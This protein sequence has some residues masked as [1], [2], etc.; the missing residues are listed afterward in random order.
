MDR[1]RVAKVEDVTLARRGEQVTGTLHL[2]PHH[3]IFSHTPHVSEEALASGTPIR[4]RE[5]W[6]TYPIISFCTLRTAP[7]VSRQPSSV[8]LRCRDFTFVCFYFASETKARDVYDTLKQWT[9]K[10]GRVEKLYAF[11]YQP[12]PP[13]QGLNGWQLYDARKEWNRQGVGREG[14]NANWRIST[15]NADYSFSPTYPALLVVPSNISDNTLNYAGRYRSR[16]RIPV[17]TYLHP[18][19]NC[20]ITRSSQPLVGVRQNRSIQD[21]KLLAAIFSTSQTDRPLAGFTPPSFEQDSTN[22]SWEEGASIQSQEFDLTN[23]EEL[24]DEVVSAAR[25]ATQEKPSVYGAQQRNLIVDAR[26]T[27][28]AFAMQAVGLGSENMDNYKFATKAYLGIDNIHVMRDSLNK[29]VEALKESDVTP[30]GPNRELLAKSNWLKY[31][32][33]ILDGAS[34]IARQV[35]LQHSHVLIH[36]SDGWDRTSQLSALSQIC[37]D[38]YYRTLE[39]FM[40]L[41]EKDWLSFGH[42]FRHRAGLLNSEKW[43]QIENER[44]GGD[45]NRSFGETSEPRKAL[46]NAFLSAKNFFN[47]KNNSRDSL[48]DDDGEGSNYDTDSP[49]RKTSSTPR[50]TVSEKETTKVKE[51][52]PVF[53]QFLDATYQLLYQ[54]PHRFEFN[55]RFLRRLLYHLYSCQY[56]TFLYNSE[57]ERVDCNAKTR[58]RSVW[59]YFLARREQFINPIYDPLVDDK[60][61]AHERLIFPR[62]DEVRWWNEA[63]GRTDAEMNGT[64]TTS[65][66]AF[67]HRSGQTT[68]RNSPVLAGVETTDT[69]IGDVPPS[70]PIPAG[71][72][73]LTT[74]LSNMSIPKFSQSADKSARKE[75][76]LEMQ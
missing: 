11:T 22:S 23:A 76:E 10:I 31:I 34:L 53:H 48:A 19:N 30:L 71:I 16:A 52:S 64:R 70:K 59:D 69:T 2:T 38:P 56:G 45:T 66:T 37:L 4:P 50:S 15:I 61:R 17:L 35:G 24:E 36:C 6:I 25:G 54:Y 3:L 75:M 9:C 47:Q 29:V 27:V 57:K 63:F 7:T 14:S 58:T 20:S 33:V 41:V 51:T 28:N 26:P 55:E 5:L 12:P 43:F 74:E 49:L 18:V 42:M 72:S 40:V 32:S 67:P 68:G 62:I 8:R 73:N 46:E 13:E 65:N 44:I 21:E 1:T 39:G 60:Q